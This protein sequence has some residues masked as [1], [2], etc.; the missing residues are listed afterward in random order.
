MTCGCRIFMIRRY[1]QQLFSVSVYWVASSPAKLSCSETQKDLH[2][3]DSYYG[4]CSHFSS[5]S[6]N[7]GSFCI[8]ASTL[9]QEISQKSSYHLQMYS[10]LASSPIEIMCIPILNS[11]CL[12]VFQTA[13]HSLSHQTSANL[14][15]H[16][17][18]LPH[19]VIYFRFNK[20]T[21]NLHYDTKP[22]DSEYSL[23]TARSSDPHT[24][25]TT[26]KDKWF[27][28]KI[29]SHNLDKGTTCEWYNNTKSFLFMLWLFKHSSAIK[30]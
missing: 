1:R 2:P 7:Q 8:T 13:N 4:I 30:M 10:T 25:R 18:E 5:T 23:L 9:S 16:S 27:F 29:W 14:Q 17:V 28:S 6:G 21:F 24:N 15:I 19:W 20:Q 11:I 3:S 22:A 26:S 12:T